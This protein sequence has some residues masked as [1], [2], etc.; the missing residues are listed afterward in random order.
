MDADRFDALTRSLSATSSRRGI[1]RLFGGLTAGSLMPLLGLAGTRAKKKCKP[2]CKGKNCGPNGCKGKCGKCQKNETCTKQGKCR[3]LPECTGKACGAGDGC[4]GTCKRGS[5]PTGH[6]CEDGTCRCTPQCGSRKCGSNGCGGSCGSC[7]RLE[8]CRDGICCNLDHACCTDRDCILQTG[9]TCKN[10]E[11]VCPDGYHFCDGA[12]WEKSSHCCSDDDCADGS[13]R[14]CRSGEC[15]CPPG[16]EES[17][18]YCGTRPTCKG[19]AAF[20]DNS[21]QCCS[22]TCSGNELSRH[23]DASGPGESCYA[24]HDCQS[25]MVCQG[26]VCFLSFPG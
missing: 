16:Q 25:G 3:C 14:T 4:G 5:C 15:T 21:P 10:G 19:R 20:C 1:A 11:C 13:G 22:Q 12:C 23:C 18:G 26:F 7:T 6:T 17:G 24:D 9:R 8:E 2:D